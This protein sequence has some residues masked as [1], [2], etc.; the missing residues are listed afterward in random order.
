MASNRTCAEQ[1]TSHAVGACLPASSFS[2]TSSSGTW[3]SCFPVSGLVPSCECSGPNPNRL[4]EVSGIPSTLTVS[5]NMPVRVVDC[6]FFK[7]KGDINTTLA[8]VPLAPLRSLAGISLEKFCLCTVCYCGNI[9]FIL[10]KLQ[11]AIKSFS[12]LAIKI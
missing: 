4:R 10:L 8:V 12:D 11:F 3:S 7:T 9:P 5:M 6:C 2:G 1:H